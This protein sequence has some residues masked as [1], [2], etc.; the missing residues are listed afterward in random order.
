MKIRVTLIPQN[1]S[2]EIEIKKGSTVTDLLQ[3]FIGDLI[4]VIVI[5][6]Q[7]RL[8]VDDTLLDDQ[9]LHDTSGCFWWIKIFAPVV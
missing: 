5:K 1:T 8:P 3:R 4:A 2:Q 7:T 9:E 6:N